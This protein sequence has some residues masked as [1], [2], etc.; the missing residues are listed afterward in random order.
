M[1]KK[2]I[3]TPG[4][5]MVPPEVLAASAKTIIHHRSPDYTPINQRVNEGLKYVFQTKNPV[6]TFSSSGT[7]AMEG[8]VTNVCSPGDKVI[9]VQGGK[10]GERW[11]ELAKAFGVE[12]IVI[13][14]VWGEAVKPAVIE[15]ALKNNPDVKAVYVTLCETSTGAL[16]DVKSIGEIV[17][18]TN[19]ILVVDAVSGLGAEEFYTD[20]YKADI[21]VTGSQKALMLPPGLAFASISE[22]AQNLMKDAKCPKYYFSYAKALK[23]YAKDDTAFTPAVNLTFALEEALKMIKAEGIENVWARHKRLALAT[24]EGVKAMNLEIFTKDPSNVVTAISVPE[25]YCS[26]VTKIL[27]DKHGITITGGQDALKGKIIRIA[28]LGYAGTFDV[29]TVIGALEL[30]LKELGHNFTLGAGVS[31][32]L[33][34]L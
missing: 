34:Y 10:F 3:L 20:D 1:E 14:V 18:K 11:T 7:G 17:A 31:K 32:T 19:A 15:E 28:T 24:R 29:L 5:T 23:A 21:V 16:T 33:E 13:D 27:R 22:K 2:Y 6:I 30:T 4:P 9:T 8:A 12:P 25:E 26:K